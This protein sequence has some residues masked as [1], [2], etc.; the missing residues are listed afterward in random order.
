MQPVNKIV[1]SDNIDNMGIL[2]PQ[3]LNGIQ[4]LLILCIAAAHYNQPAGVEYLQS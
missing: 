2:S 1:I 3:Q 4:F